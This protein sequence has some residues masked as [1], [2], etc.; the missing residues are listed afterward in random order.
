MIKAE[1]RVL[2]DTRT[3]NRVPVQHALHTS[4][5]H[6]RSK[7]IA[8]YEQQ[9]KTGLNKLKPSSVQGRS[10]I[11]SFITKKKAE[12]NPQ[13]VNFFF[14]CCFVRVFLPTYAKD[15]TIGLFPNEC[16]RRIWIASC[17]Q[18]GWCFT[19]SER[20]SKSS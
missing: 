15:A 6:K 7:R 20:Y 10:F 14:R 13:V 19:I 16:I 18:K 5:S 12:K 3:H 8:L 17:R 9:Q 11:L 4:H 1:N 2:L